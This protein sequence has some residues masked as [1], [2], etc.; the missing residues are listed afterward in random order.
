[1]SSPALS[2][3]SSFAPLARCCGFRVIV[4]ALYAARNDCIS[5][6][7]LP[8]LSLKLP[9]VLVA[10]CNQL[11]RERTLF[12]ALRCACGVVGIAPIGG[13]LHA[14]GGWARRTHG[15]TQRTPIRLA[16]PTATSHFLLVGFILRARV[17]LTLPSWSQA[18][19]E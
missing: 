16:K 3:A 15:Q 12:S 8:T 7:T 4:N 14:Q 19:V 18:R 17:E 10:F 9:A 13:E 1:M 5:R 2:S 6:Q 11:T